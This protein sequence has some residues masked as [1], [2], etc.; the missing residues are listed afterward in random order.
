[1]DFQ[2]MRLG[3]RNGRLGLNLQT[4]SLGTWPSLNLIRDLTVQ[5]T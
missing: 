1:M 3:K 2:A 4:L 5:V